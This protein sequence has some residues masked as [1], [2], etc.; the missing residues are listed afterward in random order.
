MTNLKCNVKNCYYNKNAKCCREDITVQ[1]E[2]ATVTEATSCGSFKQVSDSVSAKSCHC[3][4]NGKETLNVCCNAVH[5]VFNDNEKCRADKITIDGNG[6]V[7]ESQTE[8]GSF[9]CGC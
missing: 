9:K 7:H 1:G 5:C 4:N 3:D 6:A 8:C 2:D